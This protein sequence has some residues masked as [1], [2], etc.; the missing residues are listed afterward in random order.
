MARE[1]PSLEEQ[2]EKYREFAE[3]EMRGEVQLIPVG[4][5]ECSFREVS[6]KRSRIASAG[7]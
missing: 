5:E 2:I 4:D 7:T 1:V 3:K 6:P